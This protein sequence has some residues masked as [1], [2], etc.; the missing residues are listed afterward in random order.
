MFYFLEAPAVVA[1]IAKVAA[2]V[3]EVA[4]IEP[5]VAAIMLRFEI[6]A[7]AAIL[8]K[9]AAVATDIYAVMADITVVGEGCLGLG[10]NSGEEEADGEHYGELGFHKSSFICCE[11]NIELVYR[12]VVGCNCLRGQSYSGVKLRSQ[13]ENHFFMSSH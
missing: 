1:V 6:P 8:V 11:L 7:I 4:A 13:C 2:V 10:S 9:V 12:K 3:P 5:E